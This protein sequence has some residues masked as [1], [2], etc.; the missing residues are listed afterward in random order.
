M[1]ALAAADPPWLNLG[2]TNAT[3]AIAGLAPSIP[4]ELKEDPTDKQMKTLLSALKKHNEDLPP[5]VQVLLQEAAI[6]SGQQETKQLHSAVAAHGKAK[7]ELQEAQAA[8]MNLHASLRQFLSQFAVQ[9]QRYTEMFLQQEKQLG[10]K[11]TT[12]KDALIVARET[13]STTKISA[14]VETKDD[15][16]VM[17]DTEDLEKEVADGSA[18]KIAQGF[19]QLATSLKTLHAQAQ[20]AEQEEQ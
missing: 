10:E 18:S 17:S 19:D 11:I 3:T 20:Q 14:G 7:R 8:R 16:S 12:A 2:A 1:T 5:D 6:P 15:A 13:L 9:W 4:A